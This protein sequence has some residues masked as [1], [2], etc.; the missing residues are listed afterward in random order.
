[1]NM[2]GTYIQCNMRFPTCPSEKCQVMS[3]MTDNIH[4]RNVYIGV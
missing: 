4:N 2:P 3:C 1:M